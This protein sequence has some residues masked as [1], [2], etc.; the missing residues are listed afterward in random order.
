MFNVLALR[1][2]LASGTV[3]PKMSQAVGQQKDDIEARRETSREAN[4]DKEP[5]THRRP[6]QTSGFAFKLL[7]LG[8]L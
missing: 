7:L 2:L 3:S 1:L 6:Q 8:V 5:K 4:R